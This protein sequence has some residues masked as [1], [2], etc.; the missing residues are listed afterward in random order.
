MQSM[1]ILE[2]QT[3]QQTLQSVQSTCREQVNFK[4]SE[5]CCQKAPNA[6]GLHKLVS[7]SRCNTCEC[8]LGINSF[9]KDPTKFARLMCSNG[10]SPLKLLDF[11]THCFLYDRTVRVSKFCIRCGYYKGFDQSSGRVKCGRPFN[12]AKGNATITLFQQNKQPNINFPFEYP[13]PIKGKS[14]VNQCLQQCSLFKGIQ[15]SG[16]D[17]LKIQCTHKNATESEYVSIRKRMVKTIKP[18]KKKHKIFDLSFLFEDPIKAKKLSM[19]VDCL[20]AE[21]KHYSHSIN[22]NCLATGVSIAECRLCPYHLRVNRFRIDCKMYPTAIY[23]PYC[24]HGK[25]A[26]H[27]KGGQVSL[28]TCFRCPH[29]LKVEDDKVH[30]RYTKLQGYVSNPTKRDRNISP[31]THREK[32]YI[33]IP[34]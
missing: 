3:S 22:V 32:V 29:F 31:L 24:P 8:F 20:G 15:K 11:Y 10:N 18:P 17:V 16:K 9:G 1:E 26:T 2:L 5:V 34:D 25:G 28:Q 19:K 33:D 13:C 23:V 21:R 14:N 6:L 30:C 12:N 7:T 27:Q 4:N